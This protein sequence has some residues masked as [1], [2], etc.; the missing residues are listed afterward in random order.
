MYYYLSVCVCV[1]VCVAKWTA[2]FKK[3]KFRNSVAEITTGS[4]PCRLR[5][6]DSEYNNNNALLFRELKDFFRDTRNLNDSF[7]ITFQESG[8]IYTRAGYDVI[9]AAARSRGFRE[10][11]WKNK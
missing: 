9:A 1:C 7:L 2:Q 6:V 4:E 5:R 3:F 8:D 11:D 10:L